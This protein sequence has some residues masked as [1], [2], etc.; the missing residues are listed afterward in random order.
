LILGNQFLILGNQFYISGNIFG[1][2]TR[3]RGIAASLTHLQD[4]DSG[5]PFK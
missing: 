2:Q 5:A 1:R 4:G 3:A